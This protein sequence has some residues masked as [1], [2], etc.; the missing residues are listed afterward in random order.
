MTMNN[1]IA[2]GHGLLLVCLIILILATSCSNPAE[3]EQS[4]TPTA[5]NQYS[6]IK[7]LAMLAGIGVIQ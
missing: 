2:P 3:V 6:P 5:S 7:G 4:T 1:K